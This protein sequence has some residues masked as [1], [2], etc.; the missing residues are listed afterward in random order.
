MVFVAEYVS[1]I[2]APN[3]D[4]GGGLPV[5]RSIDNLPT[6]DEVT[7]PWYEKAHNDLLAWY[8]SNY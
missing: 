4:L 3:D 6:N 8:T 1:G 7:W 2:L 5:W